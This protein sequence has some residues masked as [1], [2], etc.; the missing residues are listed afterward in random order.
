MCRH[1]G[2]GRFAVRNHGVFKQLMNVKFETTRKVLDGI[3][4][5]RGYPL[6]SRN[7]PTGKSGQSRPRQASRR[8]STYKVQKNTQR[9]KELRARA[10]A[11]NRSNPSQSPFPI[12]KSE[13]FQVVR[14]SQF[15]TNL[16]S[17]RLGEGS[18][19]GVVSNFD[20][21]NRFVVKP[22]MLT[23][24]LDPEHGPYV[25]I[26]GSEAIQPLVVT[27]NDITPGV[28][29]QAGDILLV[30]PIT[31]SFL[32]NT[33]FRL[34][35]QNY[36]RWLPI[37]CRIHYQPLGSSLL[38]GGLVMVPLMDPHE[39]LTSTADPVFRL[40]RAMDYSNSHAFNVYNEAHMEFPSLPPDEEPFYV[41]EGSNSRFEIP[42]VLNILAQSTFA[43]D[44]DVVSSDFKRTLGWLTIDYHFRMYDAR[45][46]DLTENRTSQ[47]TTFAGSLPSVIFNAYDQGQIF[48]LRWS[49]LGLPDSALVTYLNSVFIV[50]VA[51]PIIDGVNGNLLLALN[52]KLIPASKGIVLYLKFKED[53][54][55]VTELAAGFFYASIDDAMNGANEIVLGSD[56]DPGV[57]MISGQLDI[58]GFNLAD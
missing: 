33:R 50:Y 5:R 32:A 45:L 6:K 48:A 11:R 35:S 15:N 22:P 47:T 19:T 41:Q 36:S 39:T 8:N 2:V 44:P 51:E 31:P 3:K 12:V 16:Q 57:S 55:F 52:D 24:G 58:V 40:Q 7:Q 23:Y 18:E 14:R 29:T 43:P 25:E 34:I 4:K 10:R 27:T 17:T 9:N 28:P 13:K 56:L 1:H 46:P 38:S 49:W 54:K 21:S 20:E 30:L 53:L 37:S 42:Y 26:I